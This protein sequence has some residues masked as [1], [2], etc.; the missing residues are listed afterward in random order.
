M[1]DNDINSW[2]T[3]YDDESK[4]MSKVQIQD[5]MSKVQRLYKLYIASTYF[6]QK[7]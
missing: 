7:I 6:S 2:I 5:S 3:T 1:T 4:S